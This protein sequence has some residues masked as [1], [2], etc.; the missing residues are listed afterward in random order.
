MRKVLVLLLAGVLAGFGVWFY[1]VQRGPARPTVTV[2]EAGPSFASLALYVA[3]LRGFFTEQNIDVKLCPGEA[4]ASQPPAKADVYVVPF[5]RLPRDCI[6]FALLT[7]Y[8]EYFLYGRERQ[9]S[10]RWEDVRE[11]VILGEEPA[12]DAEVVLEHILRRHG[13]RPQ[14]DV[15]LIQNLPAPLRRP[16]WEAGTGDYILLAQPDGLWWEEKG[17][18]HLAASLHEAGPVLG[19]VCA[20]PR[21]ALSAREDLYARFAAGLFAAQRW[22]ANHSAEEIAAQVGRFFP[23]L[24]YRTLLRGVSLYRD[25]GWWAATPE[26]PRKAYDR[27]QEMRGLAGEVA[28]PPPYARYVDPRTALR[29]IGL[30]EAQK[31]KTP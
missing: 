22:L 10:F 1:L 2:Y 11:K 26:P 31:E 25:T 18:A 6:A 19:V 12:A 24:N 20:A 15:H 16:A 23:H 27:L 3:A 9:S 4:L 14:T 8:P 28:A 13:L 21:T 17:K 5:D 30:I 7:N 29:G